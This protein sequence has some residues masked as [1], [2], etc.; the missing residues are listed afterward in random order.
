M[1]KL[2]QK[3]AIVAGANEVAKNALSVVAVDYRGLSVPD[4]TQL[5]VE[6][7]KANVHIQIVRNTLAR[8]ALSDTQ[9]ACLNEALV[10]P[11]MLAFAREELSAAARLIRDF[12]KTNDKVKV[13]ALALNNQMYAAN[14]L[15]MIASLPT[16]D[17]AIAKLLFVMQAPIAQFV[18]TLAEPQAKLARTLAAYR[19]KKQAEGN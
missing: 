5:R 14:Q 2:D 1:L 12:G 16:R 7:R 13:K 6:A 8:R 4:M 9:F 19:D 10:G 11:V 17:E 18:R 15:D 3:K